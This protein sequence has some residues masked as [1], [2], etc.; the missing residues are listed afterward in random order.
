MSASLG[1]LLTSACRRHGDLVAIEAFNGTRTYRQLLDRSARLAN[2]LLALGL[3]PGDRVAAMLEDYAESLEVYI[4]SAMAGFCTVHVNDRLQGEEV[5]H[6]LTDSGA[7]ALIHTSGRAGVVS[8]I[9]AQLDLP[10]RITIGADRPE[11][12]SGYEELISEGS[13]QLPV[14]PSGPEDIA[15]LGYT[16]GTTG[17]PKGAM[18]SNRAVV[19][20]T[21]MIP[22]TYRLIPQSRCAFTGSMSFVSTIWTMLLPH[23]YIGGKITFMGH[24][25]PD[26]WWS[27]MEADHTTFTYAPTPLIPAFVEYLPKHNS[28]MNNLVT[29]M[30]SA[31]TLPPSQMRELVEVIGDR[32]VEVWG[33]TETVGPLTGTAAADF[34]PGCAAED[35]FASVGRA[36]PSASIQVV[37]PDGEPLSAGETGE[38]RVEC[39][40][41]SSGYWRQPERTAGVFANG[42]YLTGD[43]GHL[44]E[45][46]YVYITDRAHDMILSGGIN[47]YPAEV[48]R[49]LA[50]LSE[51]AECA[52]FG[53]PHERWSEAVAVAIVVKPGRTL[54]QEQV[55]EHVRKHL[56]AYKKPQL[57]FFV[58]SLPRNA[59]MKI[60]KGI[61]RERFG[62]VGQ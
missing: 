28:V 1:S 60:Q 37:G 41:V 27:Q 14:N 36:L 15:I 24:Y 6:I 59:S 42:S 22:H 39:D 61:L 57:V 45:A 43:V 25:D 13:A 34:R 53:V 32:F 40:T 54:T 4:A 20:C 46:G 48:E 49:V 2:G 52:V 16:S 12:F 10:V 21:R 62:A 11:G 17:F 5:L 23:L 9:A 19:N 44:D 8:S 31:S 56:A 58:D 7:R 33:M 38:L 55:T 35:I 26:R 51:I 50:T 18:V 30:H 29:V 3:Q 47:V